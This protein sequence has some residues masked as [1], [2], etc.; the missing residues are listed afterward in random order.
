MPWWFKGI[1]VLV[2]AAVGMSALSWHD[3]VTGGTFGRLV[4]QIGIVGV[5]LILCVPAA[6][7]AL[8]GWRLARQ[9]PA[10]LAEEDMDRPLSLRV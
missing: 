1:V 5:S 3:G 6:A 4:G 7:V 8:I 9:R 2:S 10:I